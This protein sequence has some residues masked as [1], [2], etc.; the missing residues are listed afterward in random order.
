MRK[1]K[2]EG[3]RNRLHKKSERRPS[4]SQEAKKLNSI[5][6]LPSYFF[7]VF[8]LVFSFHFCSVYFI[9]FFPLSIRWGVLVSSYFIFFSFKII[10]FLF[11]IGRAHQLADKRPN[12]RQPNQPKPSQKRRR[13]KN[14][15]SCEQN[16]GQSLQSFS[17]RLWPAPSSPP[18]DGHGRMAPLAPLYCCCWL[19]GRDGREYSTSCA[20][21]THTSSTSTANLNISAQIYCNSR[22]KCVDVLR[23]CCARTTGH[24]EN[25]PLP[26]LVNGGRTFEGLVVEILHHRRQHTQSIITLDFLF[27][28]F[29]FISSEAHHWFLRSC[30]FVIF[31]S[32]STTDQ[33]HIENCQPIQQDLTIRYIHAI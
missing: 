33:T 3:K 1:K 16:V 17:F 18:V 20:L 8:P 10:F 2:R 23:V 32:F 27:S 26:R 4:S 11:L 14:K 28:F 25:P 5:S 6:L 29:V 30:Y 22:S 7:F 31:F 24:G 13:R 15:K 9:Y 12:A 21:H 19:M